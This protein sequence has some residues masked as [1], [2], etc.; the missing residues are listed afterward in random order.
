MTRKLHFIGKMLCI[1]SPGLS[2]DHS[3]IDLTGAE[4]EL[5][6]E[7]TPELASVLLV[8]TGCSLRPL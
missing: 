1:Q 8:C 6:T 3:E 5:I 4:A 7:E 2:E